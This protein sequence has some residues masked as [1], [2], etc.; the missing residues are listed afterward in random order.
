MAV[1]SCIY[2][3]VLA[4]N[5]QVLLNFFFLHLIF[6]SDRDCIWLNPGVWLDAK[7]Q[8]I[9]HVPDLVRIFGQVVESPVEKGEVKAI[10]GRTFSHLMS[11]Y[12]DQLHPFISVLPAS[13]ANALA[14]FASAG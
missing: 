6:S 11:V 14:A 3:L 10:V 7:S 1:Y 2:S 8:I 13:Q 5:P 4:S 12:G 9:P